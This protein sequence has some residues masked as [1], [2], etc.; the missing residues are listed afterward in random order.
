MH[1]TT[2]TGCAIARESCRV[3]LVDRWL[4]VTHDVHASATMKPDRPKHLLDA[5]DKLNVFYQTVLKSD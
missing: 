3:L 4:T 1:N 2:Y 5:L